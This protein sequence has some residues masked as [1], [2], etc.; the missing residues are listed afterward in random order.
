MRFRSH[1][2]F[3]HTVALSLALASCAEP[4]NAERACAEALDHVASMQV[5]RAAP[6]G[7]FADDDQHRAALIAAT[8]ETFLADCTGRTGRARYLACVLD[9]STPEAARRCAADGD[10]R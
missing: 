7:E 1:V 6:A 2:A 9:S 4:P 5:A 3:L 8:G 10:N